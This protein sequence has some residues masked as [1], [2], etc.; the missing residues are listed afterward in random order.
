MQLAAQLAAPLAPWPL[1]EKLYWFCGSLYTIVQKM[2]VSKRGMQIVHWL[3]NLLH[4]G[5]PTLDFFPPTLATQFTR[6][7]SDVLQSQLH[8]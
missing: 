8:R 5:P 2:W 7:R 1:V 3:D 6:P 4:R